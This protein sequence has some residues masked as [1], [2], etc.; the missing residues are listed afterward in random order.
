MFTDNETH[1]PYKEPLPPG[2]LPLNH[3]KETTAQVN[4][5]RRFR[6]RTVSTV[7]THSDSTRCLDMGDASGLAPC[8]RPSLRV[9]LRLA[10]PLQLPP[11]RTFAQ[12]V[13]RISKHT[14]SLIQGLFRQPV[15]IPNLPDCCGHLSSSQNSALLT[16]NIHMTP[17]NMNRE[18]IEWLI[19]HQYPSISISPIS[20]PIVIHSHT[21]LHPTPNGSHPAC[22]A[23]PSLER[24]RAVFR[25]L[26]HTVTVTKTADMENN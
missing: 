20:E 10:M 15:E 13:R 8:H 24:L 22:T 2:I 25:G 23:R 1:T 18:F 26:G 6:R 17:L 19:C 7:A 16:R 21:H 3:S 4:P 12:W 5:E 14:G 9:A 11:K